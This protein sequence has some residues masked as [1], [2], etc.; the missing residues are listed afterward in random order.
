MGTEIQDVS[1]IQEKALAPDTHPKYVPPKGVHIGKIP[2][3]YYCRGWNSKRKKYCK[4]RAG[5]DTDHTG[6]GRCTHHG[7]STPI[8]TGLYSNV[9]R[10]S[11]RDHLERIQSLDYEE[12]L[13]IM[14]E[15]DMI[16]SLAAD[17]IERYNELVEA[18]L[19]WN[20]EE[21]AD[22]ER[23]ER[24]ARPQRI[25]SIYEAQ[26]LLSRAA[27][28]VDKIHRQRAQNAISQAD[29]FRLQKAQ[30]EAVARNLDEL[31]EAVSDSSIDSL[32]EAVKKAIWEDWLD[33]KL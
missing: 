22:A 2:P 20:A 6:Q 10:D 7:G 33:L 14:P 24:S 1:K 21:Q 29:Y 3:N 8:K 12:R 32:V 26:K 31:K 9:T 17:F 19:K 4:L 27:S 13:D 28:V 25:P 15:A 16:R 18:L 5:H 30:G 23:E 11:L